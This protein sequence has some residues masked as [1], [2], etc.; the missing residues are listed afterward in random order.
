MAYSIRNI[1]ISYA[2]TKKLT[3][4]EKNPMGKRTERNLSG[5]E[6]EIQKKPKNGIS[7]EE[8]G[9]SAIAMVAKET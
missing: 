1:R 9:A 7:Y 6:T 3:F 4:I 8:K 2:R 5:W